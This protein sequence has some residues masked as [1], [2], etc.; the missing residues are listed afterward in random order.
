VTTRHKHEGDCA[1]KVH[2]LINTEG[3]REEMEKAL[4][5]AIDY[6]G[7][8]QHYLQQN[9]GTCEF[10]TAMANAERN[11]EVVLDIQ[12]KAVAGMYSQV[13]A[14]SILSGIINAR[15]MPF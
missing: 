11:L 7:K 14:R 15:H 10:A 8:A 5:E 12:T 13:I 2:D 4:E 6:L 9:D 1:L 3:K